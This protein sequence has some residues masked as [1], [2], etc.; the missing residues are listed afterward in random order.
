MQRRRYNIL[1]MQMCCR[2]YLNFV[3]GRS[4]D[5][6]WRDRFGS[7]LLGEVPAEKLQRAQRKSFIDLEYA[8]K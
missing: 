5:R 4:A 8:Y 2:L 7:V 3:D 1:Y 6:I